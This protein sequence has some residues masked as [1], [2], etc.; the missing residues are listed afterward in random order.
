MLFVEERAD[1]ENDKSR[2][3]DDPA[4]R[5]G[6]ANKDGSSI[7]L[8]NELAVRLRSAGE[9]SDQVEETSADGV[10]E[11]SLRVGDEVE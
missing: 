6:L 8:S 5:S 2:E 3:G 10:V 4:G 1:A 11:F 7:S 9:K